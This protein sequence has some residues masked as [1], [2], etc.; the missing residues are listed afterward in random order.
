MN[1]ATGGSLLEDRFIVAACASLNASDDEAKAKAM[2]EAGFTL[3]G[4]RC[5][6]FFAQKNGTQTGVRIASQSVLPMVSL[7]T[8][9]LS[10]SG[11]SEGKRQ[12]WD[13]ALGFGST[14]AL[15]SIK[16]YEDNF[17]FSS[18]NIEN[19]RALTA[20]ALN[21][22]GAAVRKTTGMTFD[23]SLQYL[24]EHQMIC[25][26]G[27]IRDLA[28]NAIATGKLKAVERT[29]GTTIDVKS[30]GVTG[31]EAGTPIAIESE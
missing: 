10:I 13:T 11:M 23:T 9:V 14:A 2:F 22:H 19:V 7:I 3:V 25:T 15:A 30:A 4:A 28:Q 31:P 20:T 21:T 29:S 16:I 26:P 17:L 5:N 12:D 18:D 24:I 8:G 1:P 27:R 6:D